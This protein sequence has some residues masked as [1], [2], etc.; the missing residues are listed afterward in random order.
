MIRHSVAGAAAEAAAGAVVV[1]AARSEPVDRSGT[2]VYRGEL[3]SEFLLN[4]LKKSP[5]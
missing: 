4:L 3:Y 2:P 1:T 5:L